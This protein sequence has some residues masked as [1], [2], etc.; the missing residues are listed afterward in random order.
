[1]I[2]NKEPMA[3]YKNDSKLFLLTCGL[4]I[5]YL[6]YRY[7]FGINSSTTSPTYIDTPLFLQVG[8]YLILVFIIALVL[9]HGVIMRMSKTS[10]GTILFSLCVMFFGL[11]KF[12]IYENSSFI[13][14]LPAYILPI[15]L[16]GLLG[17]VNLKS[18]NNPIKWLFI[19]SIMVDL[20]QVVLF[21]LYD[22]LPALAYKNSFSVRFGSFLDD[23]NG[24]GMLCFL[25][26]G[27]VHIYYKHFPRRRA[28]L[29]LITAMLIIVTQSLTAIGIGFIVFVFL[30]WRDVIFVSVI[31]FALTLALYF[32]IQEKLLVLWELKQASIE[33]HSDVSFD[34]DKLV[35]ILFGVD[36]SPTESWWFFSFKTNGVFVTLLIFLL[37]CFCLYKT[38]IMYRKCICVDSQAV[39][40]SIFLFSF[41]F[42][43]ASF[44]LPLL[45]VFPVN[46]LCFFVWAIVVLDK[47][48]FQKKISR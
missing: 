31:L 1:M 21:F 15:I 43:M 42:F 44:N 5:F 6:S 45:D 33:Q 17:R 40:F 41:C 18:L 46:F 13:N 22:R 14:Q 30:Y 23:P 19:I 4:M 3:T 8:K 35:N 10:I 25:F 32:N 24:F 11:T 27:W 48:E 2:F 36:Y 26:V 34:F 7:P 37:C 28:C 38:Y 16:A 47:F 12:L 9:I 39:S 29:Q 20:I